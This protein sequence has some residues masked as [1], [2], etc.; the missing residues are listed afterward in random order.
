ML[1]INIESTFKRGNNMAYKTPDPIVNGLTN[2]AN[3]FILRKLKDEWKE[4]FDKDEKNPIVD[5]Y[6][7]FVD[8]DRAVKNW[9]S[10]KEYLSKFDSGNL[11]KAATEGLGAIDW[12]KK[13][14]SHFRDLP[15]K[16]LR[17]RWNNYF[18][19]S[20]LG[21]ESDE[22]DFWNNELI[23]IE[24]QL[25]FKNQKEHNVW[26]DL[27]DEYSGGEDLPNL[28]SAIL[29]RIE[30]NYKGDDADKIVSEYLKYRRK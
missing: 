25:P 8:Y 2:N 7:P 10:Y 1:G 19:Y 22:I 16:S 3:S 9:N 26:T 24:N 30:P 14:E 15:P 18:D 11:P 23:D 6:N 12:L 28:T 29:S 5:K 27:S 17:E 21:G 13:H 20:G 4:K